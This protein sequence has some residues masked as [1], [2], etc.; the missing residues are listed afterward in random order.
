[1]LE[2]LPRLRAVKLGI[3]AYEGTEEDYN[4]P[5]TGDIGWVHPPAMAGVAA[6]T[7]LA[8]IGAT[9]LPPDWR[10]LSTLQRLHVIM[11][12]EA[13]DNWADLA[14]ALRP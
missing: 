8:L 7:E 2:Q 6:L 10:Q 11:D 14:G 13:S 5:G 3:Q 9:S 1:M 4:Y 12:Y